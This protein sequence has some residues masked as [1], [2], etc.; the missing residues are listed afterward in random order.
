MNKLKPKFKVK[1]SRYEL[2]FMVKEEIGFFHEQRISLI[3]SKIYKLKHGERY[4]IVF[5]EEVNK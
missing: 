4:Y 5:K 3:R 1:I 2:I